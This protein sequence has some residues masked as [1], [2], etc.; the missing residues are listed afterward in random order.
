MGGIPELQAGTKLL[1]V[2]EGWLREEK[3]HRRAAAAAAAAA[4][5][6]PKP[7]MDFLPNKQVSGVRRRAVGRAVGGLRALPG[8][9][10]GAA[11]LAG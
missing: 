2:V 5:P 9:V 10:A 1:R 3:Q 4:P 7:R 11:A 8:G 6:P